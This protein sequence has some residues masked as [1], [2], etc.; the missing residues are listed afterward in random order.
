MGDLVKSK[1]FTQRNENSVDY[2][3]PC[4]GCFNVCYG[5]ASRGISK[6]I[7]QHRNDLRHNRI[8]NTLVVH[9][10]RHNHLPR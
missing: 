7:Y 2:E 10:E 3:I 1:D 8:S 4:G 6:I 9:A 5:E